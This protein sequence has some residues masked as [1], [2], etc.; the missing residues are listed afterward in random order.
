LSVCITHDEDIFSKFTS[1]EAGY[2]NE[3]LEIE[4]N[5]R[6]NYSKSRSSN[7]SKKKGT[8]VQHMETVT[9]NET[10]TDLEKGGEGGKNTLLLESN[11]DVMQESQQWVDVVMKNSNLTKDQFKKVFKAFRTKVL[12]ADE[13]K[14]VSSLKQYFSSWLPFHKEKLLAAG[15]NKSTEVTYD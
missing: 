7:R 13:A 3:R 15:S 6:I 2:F 4:I 12:T 11:L 5:R 10:I 9:E 8:Y 14:N 1:V